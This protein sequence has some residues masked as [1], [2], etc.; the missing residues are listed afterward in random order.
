VCVCVEGR[1]RE[2]ERGGGRRGVG[3]R[4]RESK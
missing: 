1:E 2:I 4:V 3:E